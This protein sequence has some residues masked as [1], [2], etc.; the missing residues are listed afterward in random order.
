MIPH[1]TYNKTPRVMNNK[2]MEADY[3]TAEKCSLP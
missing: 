2:A 3:H 1:I